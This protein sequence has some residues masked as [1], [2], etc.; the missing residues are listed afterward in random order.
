M[1]S[2]TVSIIILAAG[3]SKRM[4][5]TI[6]QL[7]PWGD[8][9]LLGHAIEQTRP[10]NAKTYVVL[11]A[12]A[13]EIKPKLSNEVEVLKH[14]HWQN[15]MGSSIAFGVEQVLQMNPQTETIMILLA[16]QPFMDGTFLKKLL[17]EHTKQDVNTSATKYPNERVGVPAVFNAPY[18]SVLRSLDKDKGAR[19]LLN[20]SNENIFAIP[21]G[22]KGMDIDTM[23]DYQRLLFLQKEGNTL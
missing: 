1:D 4:G 14:S 3:A 22:E 11:G 15:G 12:H 23:E 17:A 9:T 18:F 21:A 5:S 16:D 13:D 19:Q 7:L 8:T 10:L 6:K 20:D 2:Q